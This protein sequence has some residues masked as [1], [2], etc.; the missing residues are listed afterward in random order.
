MGCS[1]S[2]PKIMD[3]SNPN[4]KI[5]VIDDNSILY[6]ENGLRLKNV[7]SDLDMM[8]E[9]NLIK[10]CKYLIENNKITKEEAIIRFNAYMVSLKDTHRQFLLIKN[11]IK[12]LSN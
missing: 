4:E 6:S 2:T 9:L 3:M 11:Y 10:S 7:I 8:E 1:N 5:I 12:N